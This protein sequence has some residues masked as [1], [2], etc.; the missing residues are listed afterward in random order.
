MDLMRYS[1]LHN[2]MNILGLSYC[3]RSPWFSRHIRL[4]RAGEKSVETIRGKLIFHLRSV[5]D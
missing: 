4:R 5:S 2:E 3:E 1:K